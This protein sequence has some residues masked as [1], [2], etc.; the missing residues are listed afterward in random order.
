MI[1]FNSFDSLKKILYLLQKGVI[2][3]DWEKFKTRNDY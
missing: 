2:K 1:L 3:D